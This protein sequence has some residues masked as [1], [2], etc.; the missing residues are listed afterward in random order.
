M[1]STQVAPQPK[2]MLGPTNVAPV[3]PTPSA[4]ASSQS[5]DTL[6]EEV[7]LLER[8]N[9]ALRSNPSLALEHL[10][11]HATV[12]PRGKLQ[13][14]RELLRVE[15]LKRSGRTSEAQEAARTLL[16]SSHGSL[17]EGRITRML[18]SLR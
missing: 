1:A 18:E 7:A 16:S 12:F 15:A 8:A 11:E 6:A 2:T 3:L 10:R 9:D 14:E 4:P 5:A 17:Y 13:M